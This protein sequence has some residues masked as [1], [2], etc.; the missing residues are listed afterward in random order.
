MTQEQKGVMFKM[1]AKTLLLLF[2]LPLPQRLSDS[3]FVMHDNE[4]RKDCYERYKQAV[5]NTLLSF[6][7]RG[8]WNLIFQDG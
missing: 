6:I 8:R 4:H 5:I 7:M 1:L 3:Q 2:S